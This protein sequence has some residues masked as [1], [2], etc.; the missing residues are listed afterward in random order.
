MALL[1]LA[2][3]EARARLP[4]RHEKLW[5]A[6]PMFLVLGLA[7]ARLP[8]SGPVGDDGSHGLTGRE[9]TAWIAAGVIGIAFGLAWDLALESCFR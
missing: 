1:P 7:M 6:G 2:I 4:V 5:L 9:K 8:G 3:Y